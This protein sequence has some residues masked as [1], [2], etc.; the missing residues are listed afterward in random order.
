M[1]IET[2]FVNKNTTYGTILLD[3]GSR[4]AM[5]QGH[6]TNRENLKIKQD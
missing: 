3:T 4:V 2:P 5:I 6:P 1:S